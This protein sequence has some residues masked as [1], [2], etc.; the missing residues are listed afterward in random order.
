M[1]IA[2]ADATRGEDEW[3]SFV[4]SHPFGHL[5]APGGPGRDLP[6]VVP[7]QF[8]LEDRTVW[9]H[10]VRANPIFAALAENPRVLLS[11]AD[12]WAF[13]PSSWK[14]IGDE[15]PALGIPTTYYGAV[16]LA[17]TATVHDE[18]TAPGTVAAILRRQL[19]TFQPERRGGRPGRIPRGA[20]C[21][22]SSASPSTWSRCRPSSSTAATSTS[23]TAG[24]WWS[25][26]RRGAAP[27]T[28]PRPD[29]WC[30][31]WT[32]VD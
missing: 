11:V 19:A 26:C 25:V 14:A 18:R 2:P 4:S 29:T 3:R 10:L 5:V 27:V 7:T 31:G 20:S 22:G 12:D 9:L 30:G 15:D 17:G 21:S 13:I 24:P 23:R 16:Q 28:M 6:V 8:V 32:S 1:F